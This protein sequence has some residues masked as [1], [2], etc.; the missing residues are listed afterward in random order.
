[1]QPSKVVLSL[2]LAL[3]VSSSL[4]WASIASEIDETALN[5]TVSPVTAIEDWDWIA[6]PQTFAVIP[7]NATGFSPRIDFGN[8][9]F[10]DGQQL[11][12]PVGTD[13][14]SETDGGASLVPTILALLAFGALV[15]YFTSDAYRDLMAEVYFPESY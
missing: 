6:A 1:M 11:E 13:P 12:Q 7:G 3:V 4:A 8:E 10:V 5:P 14:S 9:P 2:L 15:R